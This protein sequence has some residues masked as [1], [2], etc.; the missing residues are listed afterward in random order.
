MTLKPQREK[1]TA[2]T[3]NRVEYTPP[4]YSL[5][6]FKTLHQQLFYDFDFQYVHHR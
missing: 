5:N 6:N 3:V 1:I 4:P 2:I